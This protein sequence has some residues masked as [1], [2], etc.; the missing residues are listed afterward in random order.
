[1]VG[2]FGGAVSAP[3]DSRRDAMVVPCGVKSP[4]SSSFLPN[5]PLSALLPLLEPD[6]S[7]SGL[8]LTLR[9]CREVLWKTSLNLVTTGKVEDLSAV[10]ESRPDE[11]DDPPDTGKVD[12][13]LGP[14]V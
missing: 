13:C 4:P 6:A 11:R 9:S 1:M 14:K 12:E 3:R 2:G 8:T 7:R 5:S 10:A